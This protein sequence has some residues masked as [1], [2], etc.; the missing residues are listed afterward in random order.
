[1]IDDGKV[2]T[3]GC[4]VTT[5]QVRIYYVGRNS[6]DNELKRKIPI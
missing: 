1:M 2:R 5:N 3:E 6:R 4:I